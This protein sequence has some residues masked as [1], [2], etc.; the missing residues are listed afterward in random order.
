MQRGLAAYDAECCDACGVH[1]SAWHVDQGG[2]PNAVVPVWRHCRVCELIEQARE[3]GP[4][5]KDRVPHGWHLQL[6]HRDLSR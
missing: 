6:Q 2:H 4:P 5:D 3:V 1:R